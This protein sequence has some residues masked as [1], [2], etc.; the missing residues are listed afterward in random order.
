MFGPFYSVA[1]PLVSASMFVD[2]IFMRV[3]F[4]GSGENELSGRQDQEFFGSVFFFPE[5]PCLDLP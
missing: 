5:P 2:L 4:V 3:F 1:A